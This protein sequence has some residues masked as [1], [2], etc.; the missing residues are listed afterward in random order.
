MSEQP[1]V[2]PHRAIHPPRTRD[3]TWT[4]G[5]WA[6]KWQ[7]LVERMIPSVR[8]A[9]D[10]PT[11][12][13]YFPNFAAAAN[14]RD[15]RT[16]RGVHWS[17]GDCYKYLETL[18][19]V[20]SKTHDD[21]L[22]KELDAKIAVIAAAQESDGYLSTNIQLDPALERW[23]DTHNHELYNMGHLMTAAAVHH[24]ITGERTFL[25]VAIRNADYL[26][27][28]FQPRPPELAHYGWNPS[29]IMGLVDLHRA[30]G[31]GRYLE[32]AGIFIDMRGSAPGG[33]D[34]NQ[35]VMPV[36]RETRAMGHA[37]TGP[38][39]WAGAADAIAETGDS[40][41]LDAIVRIWENATGRRMYI[42]GGVG[43]SHWA[44][45]ARRQPV[46]EAFGRDFEL[47]NATGYNET[48]ANIALAMW[49]HRL[50]HL[51]AESRYGDVVERV[52]YNAGLSGVSIDGDTFCYTNPLRWYG[53]DHDLL[54]NDSRQRWA[55]YTCYCCPVQ[56][57]RTLAH[58]HEWVYGIGHGDHDGLW[59]HQFAGSRLTT[60]LADGSPI[61]V[62]QVTNY[63]WEGSV[64]I[65]VDAAPER[66]LS[67][68]L[69]IPA[70]A[71]GATVAVNGDSLDAPVAGTYL[72]IER[73]WRQGETIELQLP[74]EPTL[75]AAHPK[76]E[77]AR[78]QVALTRG[79]V[80]YCLESV[81]LPAGV[82]VADVHVPRDV[83]LGPSHRDDLLGGVTVLR[84]A[85]VHR[86][87]SEPAAEAELYTPVGSSVDEPIECQLV[88]YHAWNN[89]GVGEMSVW[90][91][92]A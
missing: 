88:P 60:E 71:G 74:M 87:T 28:T 47:P 84:G 29:N 33:A 79:P 85:L 38:Y 45:T 7:T 13:A 77:E 58:L 61:A 81:D 75:M 89:R 68:H 14:L 6:E 76:A 16:P 44:G 20:W 18:V 10:D 8:R 9:L 37:V 43:S 86:A 52:L 50:G 82:T 31:D 63:P 26:Y 2:S 59:I 39:L 3:V 23:S 22:K 27:R 4:E 91:P 72:R 46:H 55:T 15:F 69:R 25:D 21:T 67:I 56:V 90:L 48:C 34:Q 64:R 62:E 66:E 57:T 49:S 40:E 53:E 35:D 41:L 12:A 36:R 19:V 51:T 54:S 5:F 78:N 1:H 42:T 65:T 17:D 11:N 30:T 83:D 24:E 73:T 32:L 92:F 70:W 80:V